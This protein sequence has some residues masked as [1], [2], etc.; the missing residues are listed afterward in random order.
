MLR[1]VVAAYVAVD[2]RV[3]PLQVSVE[4]NEEMPLLTAPQPRPD[5]RRLGSSG[6]P[7]LLAILRIPPHLLLPCGTPGSRT[8]CLLHRVG[9]RPP[10]SGTPWPSGQPVPEGRRWTLEAMHRSDSEG[11]GDSWASK[12][13]VAL[14]A[15]ARRGTLRGVSRN[16]TQDIIAPQLAYLPECRLCPNIGTHDPCYREAIMSG[17]VTYIHSHGRIGSTEERIS[18]T[19]MPRPRERGPFT[20][21]S[22]LP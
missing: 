12:A 20:I 22:R 3:K 8:R 1:P 14:S 18:F 11:G 17:A 5:E 13:G 9:L 19:T 7:P 21:F 2:H 6:T 10:L 16:T 4:L 15:P